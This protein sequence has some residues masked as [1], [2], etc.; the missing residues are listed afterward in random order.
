MPSPILSE[1]RGSVSLLLT[2]NHPVPIPTF[3][4]GTPVN[5]IDNPQLRIP[6]EATLLNEH[7]ASLT[8]GDNHPMTSLAEEA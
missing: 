6:F 2:K 8:E 5:P 4:D 1:A 3:R 7:L